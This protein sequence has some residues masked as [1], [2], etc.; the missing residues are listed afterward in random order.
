MMTT[1]SCGRQIDSDRYTIQKFLRS[2]E[3]ERIRKVGFWTSTAR[4]HSSIA[5]LQNPMMIGGEE[6][7]EGRGFDRGKLRGGRA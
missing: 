5:R 4:L 2:G 3:I 7:E 6:E 1:M